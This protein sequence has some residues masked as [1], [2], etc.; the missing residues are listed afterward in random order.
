MFVQYFNKAYFMKVDHPAFNSIEML[1]ELGNSDRKVASFICHQGSYT[2]QG[3]QFKY[4]RTDYAI[5][6]PPGFDMEL[7]NEMDDTQRTVNMMD[8]SSRIFD[9]SEVAAAIAEADELPI[10][11]AANV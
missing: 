4:D 7:D 9:M 2:I 1:H 5:P 10:W 3:Y 6:T 11:S 8:A